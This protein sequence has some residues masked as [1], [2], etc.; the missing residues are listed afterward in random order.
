[1]QQMTEARVMTCLAEDCSYNCREECC[2]P[3]VEVG[4]DHPECDMF[5]TGAVAEFD[6]MPR[7]GDCKVRDCHFNESTSCVAA[8]VTMI[9][10]SGHAD[11]ATYRP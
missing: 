2:A 6:G 1:M 8:G 3:R 4:E 11:C 5:T 7:I 9:T 10:H